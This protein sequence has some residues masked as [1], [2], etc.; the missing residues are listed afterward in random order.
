MLPSGNAVAVIAQKSVVDRLYIETGQETV[1]HHSTLHI[2]V[3]GPRGIERGLL[4]AERNGL[5]EHV[6]LTFQDGV[7]HHE[8]PTDDT[9]VAGVRLR[10]L[11][12][13]GDKSAPPVL[14]EAQASVK[15]ET[16]SLRLR[17]QI[18]AP[19]EAGPRAQ[20]PITVRVTDRATGAA[21][22]GARVSLWAVSY[23]HLDVYKRQP[24]HRDR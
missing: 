3:R 13:H 11:A 22:I 24:V 6:V 12:V 4:I 1:K 17:V 15:G 5:R 8:L 9:W 18:E 7:A 19:K 21:S 23:T 10:A 16:D 20:V 14:L 2:T